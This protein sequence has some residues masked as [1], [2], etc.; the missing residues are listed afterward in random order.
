VGQGTFVRRSKLVTCFAV[1][2]QATM[3]CSLSG[4]RRIYID[5]SGRMQAVALIRSFFMRERERNARRSIYYQQALNGGQTADRES[6]SRIRRALLLIYDRGVDDGERGA[7]NS[8][9]AAPKSAPNLCPSPPPQ[10]Y[11]RLT[12]SSA[13]TEETARSTCHEYTKNPI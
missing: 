11:A 2:A 5:Y 10:L 13:D 4:V 9:F 12:R 8:V 6:A 1:D 7:D 3:A